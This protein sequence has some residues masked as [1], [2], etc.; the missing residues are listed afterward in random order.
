MHLI[1]YACMLEKAA[2]PQKL[3]P[4]KPSSTKFIPSKY[5]LRYV[6]P[7]HLLFIELQHAPHH[8]Y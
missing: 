2:I 6:P 5:T 1:L 4:R 8:Y 3:N 7:G